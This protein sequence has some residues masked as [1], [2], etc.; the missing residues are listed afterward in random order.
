MMIAPMAG[1]HWPSLGKVLSL[2]AETGRMALMLLG[3]VG[4]VMVAVFLRYAIFENFHGGKQVLRALW[5]AFRP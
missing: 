5:D 1:H 2:V 4:L 3:P